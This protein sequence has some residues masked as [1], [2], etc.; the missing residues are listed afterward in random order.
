MRPLPAPTAD[1]QARKARERPVSLV[2]PKARPQMVDLTDKREAAHW[3]ERLQAISHAQGW[4]KQLS[5]ASALNVDVSTVSRWLRGGKVSVE[6]LI[7]LSELL[8]VSLDWLLL[9]RGTPT[10][11]R[12]D[13]APYD[14]Q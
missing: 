10:G 3:G 8:N 12:T 6:H 13:Q 9:G 2:G 5:L 1:A 7:A 14:P 4:T 11:D